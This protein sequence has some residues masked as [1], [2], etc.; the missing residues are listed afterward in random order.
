MEIGLFYSKNNAEHRNKADIIKKAVRNLGLS[1]TIIE[2]ESGKPNPKLV[3]NGFDLS[4][5]LEKPFK[6]GRNSYDAI[7]KLLEKSAW[8]AMW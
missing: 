4:A 5:S 6:N 2:V 7:V 1:A 8:M 3:I